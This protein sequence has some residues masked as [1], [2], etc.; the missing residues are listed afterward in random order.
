MGYSAIRTPIFDKQIVQK[1]C[2]G[3]LKMRLQRIGKRGQA[4]FR[5]VLTEHTTKPKGRYIELLGSY[6]P[7]KKNLIVKQE[8][9][10]HWVSKG[11][12]FSPTLNNILI[13]KGIIQGEKM[14]SWRAQP[15]K[16]QKSVPTPAPVAA[17]SAPAPAEPESEKQTEV[18]AE[19]T[20]QAI[21]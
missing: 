15:S 17:E 6:D 11:A 1:F 8:R 4:Y 5:L 18:P 2:V 13:N 7:H 14:Q 12:Q 16:K 3:M 21:S 9:V 20:E 19:P 10:Q